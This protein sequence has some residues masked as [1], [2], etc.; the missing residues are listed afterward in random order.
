MLR[1]LPRSPE[2][3]AVITALRP[4]SRLIL[5][6]AYVGYADTVPSLATSARAVTNADFSAVAALEIA[7]GPEEWEHGGCDVAEQPASGVFIRGTLAALAGYEVWGGTIAHICVVTHP[8]FRGR[9]HATAAV[10]H[11]AARALQAGLVPQYRTLLSNA[12]SMRVAR[13]LGFAQYGSTIA[14]R[15]PEA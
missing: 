3:P 8:A 14:A 1:G 4:F 12:P 6:P 2:W 5:G 13:K 7:C 15:L 11:L 9:G 10:A